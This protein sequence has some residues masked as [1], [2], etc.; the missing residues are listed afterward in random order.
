MG[1]AIEALDAARVQ[2][3]VLAIEAEAPTKA[4]PHCVTLRDADP[5][6]GPCT[7][8]VGTLSCAADGDVVLLCFT[9]STTTWP[10][11]DGP[12]GSCTLGDSTWPV[13]VRRAAPAP[14]ATPEG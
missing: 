8:D 14:Q 3:V 11:A 10:K 12:V 4:T 1:M 2:E 13:S 5:A 6:S 9:G 7:C